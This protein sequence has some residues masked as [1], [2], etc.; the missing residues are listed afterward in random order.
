MQI[1]FDNAATTP[2]EPSVIEAMTKVMHD[3]F[4]NPSSVHSFGRKSKVLIESSRRKVASLLNVQ[5]AE[6]FF[7]SGG[8]EAIVMIISGIVE[9]GVNRIITSKLEH[10][11]VL[12]TLYHLEAEG[13]II[14]DFV[15]FDE[16]GH[17][18]LLEF[19]KLLEKNVKTLV[20]LMHAQNELGN[21]LPIKKVGELCLNHNALF[22]CDTV[23]T[24]GKYPIDLSA[25]FIDF[26]ICSAHKLHGPK[27]VGFVYINSRNS[28]SPL[29]FGGGQERNMRSGTENLYGIVGL[30]KAFE[31]AHEGMQ[32]NIENI[33][34]LKQHL[35]EQLKVEMPEVV[36]NGEENGLYTI[37]NLGF[38]KPRFGQEL[39][40]KLDI[41]GFAISGGSACSSGSLKDSAV[42]AALGLSTKI[43]AVRVS[44]SKYNT[45][46]EVNAL[47]NLLKTY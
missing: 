20:C 18:D 32:T 24:M 19:E 42:I 10:S 14:I 21:L 37:L 23:Q 9:S 43:Q 31:I 26:A 6:I 47:V 27:G 17:L 4:G 7:T 2:L 1:Y 38:P 22:L 3:S 16:K 44:F 29:I 40:M 45:I 46:D 30:S 11:A 25:G 15:S 33:S 34:A 39:L 41:D 35:I 13:K 8:T 28:I 5:P 36:I 12:K